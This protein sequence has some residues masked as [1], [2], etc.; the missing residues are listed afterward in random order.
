MIKLKDRVDAFVHLGKFLAK[1]S[2]KYIDEHGVENDEFNNLIKSIHIYNGWFTEENVRLSLI[3]I[4]EMLKPENLEKWISRYPNLSD[5]NTVR[6]IGVVTAG[7]IPLVGFHDMLCVLISGNIFKAKLSSKD[8][9]LM[10]AIRSFLISINP[11]FEEL[12]IFEE[13]KLVGFDAVIATGS[14]N[15]S[16]YFDYYFGKYPNIIRKNRSSIA[17]LT[18]KES[19]DEIAALADDIFMYFGLGCRN[20]S[21]LLV[22]ENYCFD[23]FF[24]NIEHYSDIYKHNK[25]ANNYDYNKSIYL[26][27]KVQHL[28][29]GFVVLKEDEGMSSPIAVLYFQYYK[30][31]EDVNKFIALN[32]HNIQCVVSGNREVSDSLDFGKAQYPELWDYADNIDT[33][34]FLMT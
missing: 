16:R 23:N 10:F 33:M 11:E 19:K 28:D 7:N 22:P 21:K 34:K 15:T 14:N 20:V 26:M 17:V 6:T 12:I 8:N 29:N 2:K 3:A 31:I 25:Y 18:G 4:S 13:N 9:K 24:K 1:F 32:S 30:T 5:N 27:N